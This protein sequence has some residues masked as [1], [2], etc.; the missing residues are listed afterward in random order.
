MQLQQINTKEKRTTKGLEFNGKWLITNDSENK[1]ERKNSHNSPSPKTD[2]MVSPMYAFVI[3]QFGNPQVY[4]TIVDL[5][6]IFA[7]TYCAI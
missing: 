5:T 7:T 3:S 1:K 6:L 4:T 2:G